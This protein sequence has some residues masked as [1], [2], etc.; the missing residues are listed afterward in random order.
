MEQLS[1]NYHTKLQ[2]MCDCFMDTDYQAELSRRIE[3]QSATLEEEALRYFALAIL[4]TL[5]VKDKQLALKI[6][7]GT[8]KVTVSSERE[9]RSLPPPPEEVIDKIVEIV[10]AITH[11]ELDH[12]E[13]PLSLGLRSGQVEVQVK[14]RKSEDEESV[15]LL[16][17]EQ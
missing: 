5:T 15:K 10:R 12:G 11:I 2:E 4:F 6:K 17:P 14:L 16:F 1:R 9:K 13:M 8:T 7:K 3:V